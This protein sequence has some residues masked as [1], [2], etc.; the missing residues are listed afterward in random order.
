MQKNIIKHYFDK[1]QPNLNF[2]FDEI[3][4]TWQVSF[5]RYVGAS[6]TNFDSIEDFFYCL[7]KSGNNMTT[8]YVGKPE[9]KD[10][11]NI[12]NWIGNLDII[13]LSK[14]SFQNEF[15]DAFRELDDEENN[16]EESERIDRTK[17]ILPNDNIISCWRI[18]ETADFR[19]PVGSTWSFIAESKNEFLYIERHW[20]S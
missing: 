19:N 4:M 7:I 12:E 14:D 1:N 13:K 15:N 9:W 5:V 6:K 17:I 2:E 11:T 16:W 8:N 10:S 3:G 20:E 18:E